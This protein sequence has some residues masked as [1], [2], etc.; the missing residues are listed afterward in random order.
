[1]GVLRVSARRIIVV[2]NTEARTQKEQKYYTET[3]TKLPIFKH[4]RPQYMYN[5]LMIIQMAT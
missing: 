3:W 2:E 4:L 1:M 5:D